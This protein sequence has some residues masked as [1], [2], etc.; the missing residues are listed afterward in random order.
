M[1]QAVARLEAT[2]HRIRQ[3]CNCYWGDDVVKV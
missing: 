1:I 3:W 2:V